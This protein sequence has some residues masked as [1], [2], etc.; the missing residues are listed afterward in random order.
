MVV[1]LSEPKESV[2]VQRE[3]RGCQITGEYRPIR[4][5]SIINVLTKR[6]F[7]DPDGVVRVLDR[8]DDLV[9]FSGAEFF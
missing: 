8:I 9:L 6:N 5:K 3:K 4:S 1:I 7:Y 2:E